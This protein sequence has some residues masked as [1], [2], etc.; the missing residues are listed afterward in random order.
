M[1]NVKLEHCREI[2]RSEFLKLDSPDFV[3]QTQVDTETG[4]AW[5]VWRKNGILYKVKNQIY[6]PLKPVLY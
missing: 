3:G 6:K 2:E 5:T 1:A 4:I